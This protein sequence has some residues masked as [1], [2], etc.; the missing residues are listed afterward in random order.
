M[1]DVLISKGKSIDTCEWVRGYSWRSSDGRCYIRDTM[2]TPKDH[3]I[4]PLS[5]GYSTEV[6]DRNGEVIFSGDIVED[7]NG[8]V[9]YVYYDTVNAGFCVML[10]PYDSEDGIQDLSN[11]YIHNNEPFYKIIGNLVDNPAKFYNGIG[12]DYKYEELI[13]LKAVE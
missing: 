3:E 1:I 2:G 9:G 8:Y 6:H 13:E 7:L 11:D 5:V 10:D 12:I 4:Y